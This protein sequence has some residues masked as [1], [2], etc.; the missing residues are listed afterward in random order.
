[1]LRPAISR[2]AGASARAPMS[3]SLCP[4]A[5]G[6]SPISVVSATARPPA[7]GG[8]GE[9]E[10]VDELF[11]AHGVRRRQLAGREEPADVRVRRRVDVGAER[12]ERVRR[13]RCESDAHHAGVA[14]ATL[15]WPSNRAH[16][17]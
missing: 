12:R 7:G 9:T 2:S 11:D 8:V 3:T 14:I 10:V 17:L 16:V 4:G 15:V 13:R 1:M 5:H 6:Q